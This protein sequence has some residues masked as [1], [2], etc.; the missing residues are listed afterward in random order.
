M[1]FSPAAVWPVAA[2]GKVFITDPQRAMTAIDLETGETVWRTFQSTVRETI[3]LSEDKERVYSKT[4][5]DSIVCFATKGDAPVQ[6]WAS[7]VAFGY[8]HAPSMPVEKDGVVFGSTKG[9]LIFA[10][11]ALT[12]KVLWKHKIGNSLISTVTPLNNKQVLFTATGGEVGLL[13]L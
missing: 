4:M 7:N 3:G 8:E 11:D 13:E 6:L 5:N 10:L 1:H 9:G 12:G 2:K